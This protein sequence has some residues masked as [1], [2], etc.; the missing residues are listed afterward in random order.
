MYLAD[1]NRQLHNRV[2]FEVKLG[3]WNGRLVWLRDDR[4]RVNQ[5]PI[6]ICTKVN[7]MSPS[8]IYL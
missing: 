8:F 1:S 3:S 6:I 7:Y 5:T 4:L 2:L